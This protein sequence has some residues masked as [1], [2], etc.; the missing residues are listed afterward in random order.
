MS[1]EFKTEIKKKSKLH[2]SH[3]TTTSSKWDI[4]G[5]HQR[6]Q[7]ESQSVCEHFFQFP[8]NPLQ[9]EKED[10]VKKESGIKTSVKAFL[11]ELKI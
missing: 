4:H 10:Y 11:E 8:E 1:L 2:A 5:G 7:Q 6:H 3:K 9:D